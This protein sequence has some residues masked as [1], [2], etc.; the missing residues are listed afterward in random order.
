MQNQ[1]G[2][3]VRSNICVSLVRQGFKK[4]FENNN[5]VKDMAKRNYVKN[6]F[7]TIVLYARLYEVKLFTCLNLSLI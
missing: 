1:N 4:R 2:F 3:L 6:K 5:L 7:A